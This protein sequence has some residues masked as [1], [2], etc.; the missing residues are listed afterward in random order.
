MNEKTK[1]GAGTKSPAVHSGIET[2]LFTEPEYTN[3][4][5]TC[6][7]EAK[8]KKKTKQGTEPISHPHPLHPI[9]Q[10]NSAAYLSLQKTKVKNSRI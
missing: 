7:P 2:Y 1:K 4:G 8:K 10:N 6:V 9:Y 3:T 5:Q